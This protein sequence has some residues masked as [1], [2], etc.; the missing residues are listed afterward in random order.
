MKS[1]RLQR[2]MEPKLPQTD[3]SDAIAT[4]IIKFGMKRIKS[5]IFSLFFI[6]LGGF[7]M[8][9]VSAL[10]LNDQAFS[11][12]KS[13]FAYDKTYPLESRV[14]G[15]F[16]HNGHYFE[17][18]TFESFHD[19]SVPGL[20]SV[21][22]KGNAPYPVVLLLHGITSNK[23]SWL[24]DGFTHGGKVTR[25]LLDEGYAVFALDAQYHGRRLAN[26]QLRVGEM[27]FKKRW[28]VR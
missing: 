11:I 24:G 13:T 27:V 17:N 1:R 2:P 5:P 10:D 28:L 15:K 12:L 20:L 6:S 22:D 4:G 8:H 23:E 21:P 19:G 25:R 14:T 7:W 16:R 9:A 3:H 26:N 18:I